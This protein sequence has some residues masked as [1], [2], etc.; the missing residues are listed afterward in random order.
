MSKQ[1]KTV[2]SI[3][4]LAWLSGCASIYEIEPHLVDYT[5]K[6]EEMPQSGIT[7]TPLPDSPQARIVE[8]DGQRMAAFDTQGMNDLKRLREQAKINTEMLKEVVA[9]ND[10]LIRERND[11]LDLAEEMEERSNKLAVKWA[12]TEED[13]QRADD[14]H[15]IERTVYQVGIVI[16]LILML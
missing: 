7:V 1:L 15:F 16:A 5:S 9:A 3:L 8:V 14:L 6:I 10:D 11:I 12:D 13:K 4:M 2:S